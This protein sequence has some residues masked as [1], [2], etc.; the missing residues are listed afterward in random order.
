MIWDRCYSPL[1]LK[2]LK[3]VTVSGQFKKG[4][5]SQAINL[6]KNSQRIITVL[7]S[8]SIKKLPDKN[9]ADALKRVAGV[10][11]QNNKGEGGYVSLRGTPNDWTSTLINGDRLPVADEE[12]TSRSF[13]FEVLPSASH[14]PHRCDEDRYAGPG[15]RQCGRQYQLHTQR[16]CGAADLDG[17]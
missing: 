4:S 1:D 12:N 15:G 5:E 11:I 13:E 17:Q 14:R 2:D 10:T 3:E 7:S 9:A 8:E 6:T 16:A